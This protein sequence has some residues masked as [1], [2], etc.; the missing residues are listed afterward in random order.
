MRPAVLFWGPESDC[1]PSSRQSPREHSA[2]ALCCTR[3]AHGAIGATEPHGRANPAATDALAEK[4]RPS[5]ESSGRARSA[6]AG[7][8]CISAET[9][10]FLGCSVSRRDRKTLPMAESPAPA[11][12]RTRSF[13]LHSDCIRGSGP[14]RLKSI[15]SATVGA[16]RSVRSSSQ[17]SIL[18]SIHKPPEFDTNPADP[19][20]ARRSRPR[21]AVR[22][23]RRRQGE[24]EQ[25]RSRWNDH[26]LATIE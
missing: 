26:V 1:G 20:P 11:V 14:R 22:H 24:G 19:R 25:P 2:V 5:F 7:N 17:L 8:R 9:R 18:K 12:T 13:N 10:Q 15:R 4:L 6:D 21:L 23:S 3:E 16:A